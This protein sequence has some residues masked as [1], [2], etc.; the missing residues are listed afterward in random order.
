LGEATRI[1]PVRGN[2]RIVAASLMGTAIEYYDWNIYAFVAVLFFGPLF[3][4]TQS[5]ATQILLSLTTFAAGF[6]ARPVGAVAFGHFGDRV[7][8][9]STLVASLLLMGGCT[10]AIATLPTYAMTSRWL[11]AGWIA[12][13]LLCLLRFGQGFGLGGEWAGA[14]L[15]SIEYAPKGWQ[16]RF[17]AIPPIGCA[18]GV[19]AAFAMLLVV[20]RGLSESDFVAW[21]WR[22]P[23]LASAA[24]VAIGLWVRLK[25]GETPEFRA[26]LERE[27]PPRMPIIRVFTRHTGALLAGAAAVVCP[28]ALAYMSS[29]FALPRAIGPLG[30]P[31]EAFLFVEFIAALVPVPALIFAAGYAERTTLARTMVLGGLVTVPVGLVFEASLGSHSLWIAGAMLCAAQFAWGFTYAS[32]AAWLTRLFPVQVRYSGFAV[33]FNTGGIIGALTPIA[34]QMMSTA[35]AGGYVGLL[36]SAAGL[37]IIAA[38]TLVRP[39]E[40]RDRTAL[41]Q[42]AV[43]DSRSRQATV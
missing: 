26:A 20:G 42:A 15:L 43:S 31:R 11:G 13:A 21:G 22:L 14:A 33:A 41:S 8:R 25:I 4:P 40:L 34:A 29:V 35:G 17:G 19:A 39:M 32:L 27:R 3:F 5:H 12:P 6:F 10:V 7:G 24:L 37:L 1:T 2:A 16:A 38:V 30:Y 9:K 18:I 36:I 23:F 28:Y